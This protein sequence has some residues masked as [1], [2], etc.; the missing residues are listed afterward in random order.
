MIDKDTEQ[1]EE[2]QTFQRNISKE[3]PPRH[4][5]MKTGD[6][7]SKKK[8]GAQTET[9]NHQRKGAQTSVSSSD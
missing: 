2:E 6:H 1:K 4:G 5:R 7:Q 8:E 9:E 3:K